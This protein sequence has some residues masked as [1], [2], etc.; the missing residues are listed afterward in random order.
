[1]AYGA[2]QTEM[3]TDRQR[4]KLNVREASMHSLKIFFLFT[5]PLFAIWLLSGLETY[6]QDKQPI[7][8]QPKDEP[9]YFAESWKKGSRQIEPQKIIIKLDWHNPKHEAYIKDALGTYLYRLEIRPSPSKGEREFWILDLKLI[10]DD[11]PL[12]V[13]RRTDGPLGN[14]EDY[15]GWLY[16]VKDYNPRGSGLFK[17]PLSAKR[18]VK[19]EGFYCVIQ[20]KSY[21]FSPEKNHILD[22]I[23]VEV[24][25]TNSY[26]LGWRRI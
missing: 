3:P 4:R 11:Y 14:L 22:S 8:S 5:F 16:P 24:E 23:E 17:M 9:V 20:V 15:L 19:I 18:V 13:T 7:F 1:M 10:D 12:L 25:F 21:K 26:K 6:S 2:T